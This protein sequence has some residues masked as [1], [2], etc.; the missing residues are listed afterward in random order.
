MVELYL[1]KMTTQ[2]VPS[3]IKRVEPKYCDKTLLQYFLSST[4]HPTWNVFEKK[5][6]LRVQM[7]ATNFLNHEAAYS[8]VRVR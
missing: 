4:T 6:G 2:H 5:P 8:A 3:N 7:S 1:M